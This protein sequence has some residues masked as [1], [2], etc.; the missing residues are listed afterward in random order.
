MR[1]DPS[2][3]SR[4]A[5]PP[6]IIVEPSHGS[7][8]LHLRELWAYREL[9]YFM[10][11]RDLRVR[12]AQAVV[13]IGWALFVPFFQMIVFSI[14]FGRLA[15]IPSDGLPYPIFAYAAVVPW[16]FFAAGLTQTANSLVGSSHLITKVYFPRLAVPIAAVLTGLLDFLLAFL[17]L[18]GMM[19]YFGIAP[20]INIVW[21]PL[22]VLLAL[23]T[24][25]GTGLWLAALNVEYRD[26]RHMLPFITQLWFCA[27]PV[28]YPSSLLHGPWRAV[29][30][31]NPM[32]GVIEGFRWALLRTDTVPGLTIAVSSLAS[33]AILISGA[34]H[35]RRMERT[36]ADAL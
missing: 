18:F 21:L 36:F 17:L 15:K 4:G 34:Y 22:L 28:V 10:V 13:G 7:V 11:W 16:T 25:L 24:A 31:L 33:L 26:V 27:T 3:V 5:A 19:A 14:F 29:S 30:G 32:V 6:V 8:P 2:P 12:Y 1:C 35:F 9:V 20:T 23:M